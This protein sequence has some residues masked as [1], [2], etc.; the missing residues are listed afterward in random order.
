[1]TTSRCAAR[2]RFLSAASGLAVLG[3]MPTIARATYQTISSS[4][5]LAMD[6]THTREKIELIYAVGTDYVPKALTD[7]SHFLRD[8]YSGHIGRMDAGL[9]DIMHSLRAALKVQTSFEIISGYRSPETNE[10]LRTTRGGGVAR[11][12]LHMDGKAVDLRLPGVPLDELRDAALSLKAGGVGY[13]PGSNF[14][15]VDTGRVRTWHG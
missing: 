14:V 7:L 11:R 10:R 1:M 6:H 13:Y 3:A 5:N 9:Y 12:S 2:R 15:H 8:H 4:R